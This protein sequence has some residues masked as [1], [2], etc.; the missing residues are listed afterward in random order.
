VHH[1]FAS[2]A[3]HIAT[4]TVTDAAGVTATK[5][6]A[7]AATAAAVSALKLVPAK[8]RPAK[9]TDVRFKLSVAAPVRFTV[10]RR[11]AGRKVGGTCR[12]TTKK[13]RHAK[14]CTRYVR[15]KGSFVRNGVSGANHFHWNGRLKGK[16]LK[17]GSYR[18][19]ATVG[20]GLTQLLRRAAFTIKR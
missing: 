12:A 1:A 17:A 7:V 8:F 16:A 18:L 10:E 19:I 20:S 2:P 9:G 3:I 15:V 5:T 4:V 11:G 14:K 6:V 13:N